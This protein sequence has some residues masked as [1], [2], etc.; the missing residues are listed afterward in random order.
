MTDVIPFQQLWPQ[1]SKIQ[2][3]GTPSFIVEVKKS[4]STNLCVVFA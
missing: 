1:S 2:E 4:V 3:Y